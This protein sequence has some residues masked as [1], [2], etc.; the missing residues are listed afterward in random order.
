[1]ENTYLTAFHGMQHSFD[2]TEQY[3]TEFKKRSYA[4]AFEKFYKE[5]VHIFGALETGY[6]TAID[7]ELYISNMAYALADAAEAIV[8]AEKSKSK[9]QNKLMDLNL[10]MVVYIYPGILK[11]KGNSAKPVTD[12]LQTVWKE[13]FPQSNISCTDY[14]TIEG[15]FHKKFCYITTAVCETFGKADDCYELTLLREYRDGYLAEQEDGESIIREYYDVAP[16]IVK[17]I[18][19]RDDRRE[20]YSGLWEDYL[21]PCIRMIE[22]GQN[23]ECREHYIRMVRDLEEKYFYNN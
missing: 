2:Q 14:E 17:R 13:K 15:G 20:I 19:R 10:M 6:N 8:N 7:K 21:R 1:M 22:N 12:K 4:P 11:Y 23:Q 5:H 9:K 16:T 18:D 3:M